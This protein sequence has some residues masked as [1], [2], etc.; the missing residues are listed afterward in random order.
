[1]KKLRIY[2]RIDFTILIAKQPIQSIA[3]TTPILT[4][5]HRTADPSDAYAWLR[6]TTKLDHEQNTYYVGLMRDDTKRGLTYWASDIDALIEITADMIPAIDNDLNAA[7]ITS[8][9]RDI[10]AGVAEPISFATAL[11]ANATAAPLI[12]RNQG[13]KKTGQKERW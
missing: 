5:L 13:A 4:L 11:G 1:M 10:M 7:D 6:K 12:A 2:P 3:L 9:L 8:G